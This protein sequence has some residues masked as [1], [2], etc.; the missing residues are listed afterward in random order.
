MEAEISF[1]VCHFLPA[2]TKLGQGNIFTGVCLS[3]GGR[4]VCLSACWDIPPRTR[5]TPPGA[6]T[7]TGPGRPPRSRHPPGPGRNPPGEADFSI[8]STRGRYASYWNA[9]LFFDYFRFRLCFCAVWTI[10]S[11]DMRPKERTKGSSS[12]PWWRWLKIFCASSLSGGGIMS[13]SRIADNVSSGIFRTQCVKSSSVMWPCQYE[14]IYK[15]CPLFNESVYNDDAKSKYLDN[16]S[17]SSFIHHWCN[18]HMMC[19]CK[20]PAYDEFV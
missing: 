15:H 3:T 19:I 9:F 10:P 12:D 5:Q 13:K 17:T 4:G 16:E 20:D 7:P 11:I 6:D 1:D 2:A 8:R 14:T 18:W